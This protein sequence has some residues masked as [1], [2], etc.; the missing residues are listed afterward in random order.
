MQ[1]FAFYVDLP[2]LPFHADPQLFGWGSAG[3]SARVWIHVVYHTNTPAVIKLHPVLLHLGLSV[4]RFPLFSSLSPSPVL[5]TAILAAPAVFC[6][7]ETAKLFSS[8]PCWASQSPDRDSEPFIKGSFSSGYKSRSL[9]GWKPK[10]F[11]TEKTTALFLFL[12]QAGTC[13]I[14]ASHNTINLSPPYNVEEGCQMPNHIWSAWWNKNMHF[15]LNAG[16]ERLSLV[17]GHQC[18]VTVFM[19]LPV[20]LN[21]IETVKLDF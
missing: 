7:K 10:K 17:Y 19:I 2:D 11:L 14:T 12:H 8:L 4:H 5:T 9:Q 1:R 3:R 15:T 18:K 21:I 13:R 6:F 16:S 20:K